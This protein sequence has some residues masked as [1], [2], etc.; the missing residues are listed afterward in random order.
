M[1]ES[2]LLHFCDV[3]IESDLDTFTQK[4]WQATK[5]SAQKWSELDGEER[6]IAQGVLN[7]DTCPQTCGYHLQCYAVRTI[8][9]QSK[10]RAGQKT[11]R[12]RQENWRDIAQE[13]FAK[14]RGRTINQQHF[15]RGL[16]FMPKKQVDQIHGKTCPRK[17]LSGRAYYYDY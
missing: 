2:C 16:S 10:D 11:S 3:P 13:T 4:R 6:K 5:A 7:F 17:A 12:K 14:E 8:Q 15:T 1:A 9:Q